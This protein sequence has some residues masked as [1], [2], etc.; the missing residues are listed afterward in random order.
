MRFPLQ[1]G[2]T[3]ARATFGAALL[4]VFAGAVAD[5]GQTPA[6]GLN[7]KLQHGLAFGL[8][9]LLACLA[10]P[11]RHRWRF[12]LPLLLG[13]GVLIE[14]VQWWLPWREF[15]LPDL[16]ADLAGL[17]LVLALPGRVRPTLAGDPP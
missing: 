8:L 3:L 2:S 14:C 4:G 15:S 9:A 1:A 6:A 7:D 12:V 17:L 16:A 10:M 11:D 13:Y 5:P